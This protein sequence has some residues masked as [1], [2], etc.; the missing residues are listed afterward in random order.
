M[1]ADNLDFDINDIIR[2]KLVKNAEKYPLEKVKIIIL[3]IMN[4]RIGNTLFVIYWS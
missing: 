4:C 2:K 3:N 1:L